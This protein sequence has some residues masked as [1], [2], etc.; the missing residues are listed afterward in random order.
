MGDISFPLNIDG[1]ATGP[2]AG[3]R[4]V[5]L[6]KVVLGPLATQILGDMGADVI[7]IESPGDNARI[8]PANVHR[9]E[10]MAA[11][12][13]QL[14]RNK[15]SVSL[16]L[17]A[18]GGVDALLDLLA[19]ADVLVTNM[20]S[21]AL[22]KLGID[23]E[24]LRER[25]PKLIYAHAQGFNERS[26]AANRPAYDEVIQAVSGIVNMQERASGS[27]QFLPTFIADK[28]VALY[29]AIGVLGA[30]V[31]QQRTGRGQLVTVAMA[32]AMIAINS[33]EHLGGET[34]VPAIGE[35]GNPLSLSHIHRAMRTK[36]GGAIA[37]VAYTNAAIRALLIGAGCVERAADPVWDST[38]IDRAVFN[39]GWEEILANSTSKTTAEWQDYLSINDIP[40]GVVTDIA[41]LPNDDYVREMG[42]I[43]EIDHP[44]EGRI[45]MVRNPIEYS[46]TPTDIR[47]L[48]EQY[49]ASTADVLTG[50]H[51]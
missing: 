21:R 5:D 14:N 43:S 29:L 27:L 31:D 10:G 11:L 20:R 36:D 50:T 9:N 16:D 8:S 48:P 51:H 35:V 39:A 41:D 45:R 12:Y 42:L 34:F 25:F 33:V 32:D 13:M 23:Y 28:T 37:A 4:V 26:V 24:T 1:A 19:D 40:Y 38:A 15:R 47:R 44:T 22:T 30:V 6:S 18:P 46:R 17:K 2:L 49:G 7:R 3:I